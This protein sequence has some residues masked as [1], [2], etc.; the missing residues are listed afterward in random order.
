MRVPEVI[1]ETPEEQRHYD[2]ALLRRQH[3]EAE[4]ER[5]KQAHLDTTALE[6]AGL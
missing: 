3:R 2:D 6:S 1:P 4:A 5:R